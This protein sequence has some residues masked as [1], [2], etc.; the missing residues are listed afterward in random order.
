[1]VFRFGTQA[2]SDF[3]YSRKHIRYTVGH[4]NCDLHCLGPSRVQRRD[5]ANLRNL[6]T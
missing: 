5:N 3:S 6:Y 4:A 2:A 1:M